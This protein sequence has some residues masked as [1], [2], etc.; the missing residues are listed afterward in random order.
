MPINE[1]S[2]VWEGVYHSFSEAGCEPGAFD[3]A[4]WHGKLRDRA[5]SALAEAA[6][7]KPI[8]AATTVDDAL[9]YL[10]AACDAERPIRILDFGGG[11]G[12]SYLAL[13]S[14]LG[15]GRQLHFVVV[16]SGT[17][18]RLGASLFSS[19]PEISFVPSIPTSEPFDIVHAGSSIHYVEDWRGTLAELC[20]TG[21]K[22]LIF[23]DLPAGNIETFVTTQHYYGHKIPVWFWN[24]REFADCIEDQGFE[25]ILDA[26]YRGAYLETGSALPTRHFDD[27]YRLDSFR[28][29][30]FRRR[31][32]PRQSSLTS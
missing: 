9:P 6:M 27:G 28:Q 29:L 24:V 13:R 10:A 5:T 23:V 16:E 8:A 12:L 2:R 30:V 17:V 18:C 20:A 1:H 7:H 25:L 14:V 32:V 4:V 3:G 19:N 21:A 22:F 26:E 11:A 15:S 31:S